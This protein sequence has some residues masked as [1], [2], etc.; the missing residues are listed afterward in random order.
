LWTLLFQIAENA[1]ENGIWYG[2]TIWRATPSF[3]DLQG[4]S[5]F[6]RIVAASKALQERETPFNELVLD[7]QVPENHSDTAPLLIAIHGN[8]T[9]IRY[10]R[11]LLFFATFLFLLDLIEHLSYNYSVNICTLTAAYR[12]PQPRYHTSGPILL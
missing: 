4:N 8:E 5:N 9:T 1:L 7:I 12:T 11:L 2:E 10:A 3:D 6:E